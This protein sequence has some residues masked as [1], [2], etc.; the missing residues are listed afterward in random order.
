MGVEH[1]L[2][3]L[4]EIA[5]AYHGNTQH[6]THAAAGLGAYSCRTMR[7]CTASWLDMCA[8]QQALL[9]HSLPL[10]ASNHI[11]PLYNKRSLR[12]PAAPPTWEQSRPFA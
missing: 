8:L 5:A 9:N 7:I 3:T 6:H 12:L 4:H 10:S 2:S 1:N 11:K